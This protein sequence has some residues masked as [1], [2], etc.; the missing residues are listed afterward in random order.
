MVTYDV[1]RSYE[2]PGGSAL[3]YHLWLRAVVG[4]QVDVHAMNMERDVS[5]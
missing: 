4:N 5:I 1:S 3:C 2:L